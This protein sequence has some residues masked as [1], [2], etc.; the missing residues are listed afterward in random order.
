M[1]YGQA[2]MRSLTYN[3]CLSK[4]TS[5]MGK[6]YSSKS[7]LRTALLLKG[8]LNTC[9]VFVQRTASAPLTLS[10]HTT[11]D[12]QRPPTIDDAISCLQAPRMGGTDPRD[13]TA[14]A[15]TSRE[16]QTDLLKLEQ[17]ENLKEQNEGALSIMRELPP[18]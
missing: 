2:A 13:K 1:A 5:F 12:P 14:G 8:A 18:Y 6:A 11:G 15:K 17:N 3:G 16:Q 10:Q 4:P 9:T 7:K